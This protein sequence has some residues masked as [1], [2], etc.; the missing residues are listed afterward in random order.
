MRQRTHWAAC[1][2]RLRSTAPIVPSL[3]FS[4]RLPLPQ[5]A[6]DCNPALPPPCSS[7]HG[8]PQKLYNWTTL[9]QKVF[10]KLSF[11]LPKAEYEAVAGCEPGAVER[12]LKLLKEKIAKYQ[13]TPRKHRWEHA[14]GS[15]G[16][17]A[18]GR[19][20]SSLVSVPLLMLQT[21]T[22]KDTVQ[23]PVR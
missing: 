11:A 8:L 15:G 7:A 22:L 3:P 21:G 12:V 17:P 20:L 14:A 23:A 2:P 1:R 18:A 16:Q 13:D 10:K 9:N 5:Q 4:L 19:G 6:L